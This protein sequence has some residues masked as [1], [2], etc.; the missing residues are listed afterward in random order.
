MGRKAI[1]DVTKLQLWTK[2]GGRC[3]FKGCNKNLLKDDLSYAEMNNAHIAHIIDVNKKTHRYSGKYSEDEKNGLWNLMLLCQKHHRLIDNEEE[4]NYPIDKLTRFKSEHENR[5]LNLTS[6][7]GNV[8]TEVICYLTKIGKFQPNMSFEEVK[9]VLA[10][11]DLYPHS[12]PIEIGTKN[13][14]LEDNDELYWTVEEKNLVLDFEKKILKHFDSSSGNHFSLFALAPQPLLIRLGTL[15]PDIYTV[16]VYQKH[17]EPDTW[18]WQME[19]GSYSG[20]SI[21][22]PDQKD[23]LPV[24][25][26]SL[27]ADIVEDRITAVTKD[28]LAIWKLTIDSPNNNFLKHPEILEDFRVVV[29]SILNRIK[30]IHGHNTVLKV[31]PCMPNSASIEFGRVWMPKADMEMEI[32]DERDGFR[33]AITIKRN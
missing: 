14:T 10:D 27:S 16:D 33:K 26:I 29:R 20:F 15:I 6:I 12:E 32:Y 4:Q 2:S 5:I 17:R 3:Q 25:N 19:K 24:L 23:G 1:P 7:K 18:K 13:S 8:K 28:K 9:M 11:K 30:E 31:F 21:E 22:E